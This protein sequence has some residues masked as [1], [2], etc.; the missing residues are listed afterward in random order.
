MTSKQWVRWA[1]LVILLAF[2]GYMI[3]S[4]VVDKVRPALPD[5]ISDSF[6]KALEKSATKLPV[7]E[8]RGV[9]GRPK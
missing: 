6:C 5:E 8:C 7:D 2:S 4:Y 1:A 9:A 3:F